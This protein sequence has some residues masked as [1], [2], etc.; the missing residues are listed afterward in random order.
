MRSGLINNQGYDYYSAYFLK[1]TVVL[2]PP[3]PNALL[4]AILTVL[5][6]TLL[7]V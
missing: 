6:S 1:S 2:C 5:S 7:K 4:I 3:K